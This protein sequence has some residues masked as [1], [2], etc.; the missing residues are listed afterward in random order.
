MYGDKNQ[1]KATTLLNQL[2]AAS[3]DLIIP[4]MPQNDW[5]YAAAK[6]ALLYEF[7]N[8]FYLGAQVLTGSES[9]TVHDA[10]IALRSAAKPYK[11]LYHT[12]MPVFKDNCSIDD[13]VQYLRQCGDTFGPPN[14]LLKPR[15]LPTPPVCTEGSIH[16]AHKVNISKVTCHCCNF[17]GICKL[18][19]F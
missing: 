1:D 2:D 10:H 12:L 3:T 4:R 9:L 8:Q 6:Q 17:K 11:A 13:M 18:L 7:G 15:P 14:A 16:F 5:S 19:H